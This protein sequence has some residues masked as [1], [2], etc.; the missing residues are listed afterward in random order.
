MKNNIAYLMSIFLLT[1]CT[2]PAGKILSHQLTNQRYETTADLMQSWMG[3]SENELITSWGPPT[4]QHTLS[5]ASK[6]ISY[7][8][9]WGEVIRAGS[10][11]GGYCIQK[12]LIE[13]GMVTKW[14]MSNC[15][16]T[17][18]KPKSIS[19]DIPIPQPSLP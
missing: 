1:G 15:R 18:K 12:F 17:P 11:T 9:E 6:I 16:K 8:Y 7:E 5:N 14:G 3:A 13:K 2:T 10:F 19:T 4:K